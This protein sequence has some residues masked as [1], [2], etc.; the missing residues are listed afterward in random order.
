MQVAQP[1]WVLEQELQVVRL[2]PVLGPELVA[3]PGRVAEHEWVVV[4]GNELGSLVGVAAGI[5]IEVGSR[6]CA[7][8]DTEQLRL[9][10]VGQMLGR[11][12]LDA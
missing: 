1:E 9:P 5:R 6:S 3:G 2:E 7:G 8:L 12:L 11:T 4:A 10:V